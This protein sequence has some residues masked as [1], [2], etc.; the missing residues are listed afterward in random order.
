[1][2][3]RSLG[4]SGRFSIA[5]TLLLASVFFAAPSRA[6]QQQQHLIGELTTVDRAAGR[7]VVKSD[8]GASFSVATGERTVFR[9]VPPGQTS[10]Q[11]AERIDLSDLRVGDRVLVPGGA[12]AEGEAARQVVVMARE[13]IKSRRE[14]ERADWR[15]RGVGGRVVAIDAEKRE[16]TVEAR[17]REGAQTVT[18]VAGGDVRFRRFAQGSL[19]LEDA[20]QGT[21]ADVRVGDQL[22][23]LGERSGDGSRFTAEE[24]ISG[25]VARMTGVVETIDAARNELVVKDNQTGQT[26]TIVLVANTSIR[27]IPDDFMETLQ[28]RREERRG[29][30]GEANRQPGA[31]RGE[32]RGEGGEPDARRGERRGGGRGLQQLFENLPAITLSDLKKGDAVIVTGTTGADASRLTAASIVAGDA[33]FLRRMQRFQR[34]P[35]ARGNMSPGL[36]G[37]VM[38]G[39]TGSDQP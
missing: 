26:I 16:I 28:Q 9:R 7:L 33:E 13:A 20:V 39:N 25:S 18:V 4:A 36:P 12:P 5:S 24:I 32:R 17:S 2:V 35:G 30:G 8:A 29:A 19:R 21:F 14:G 27:R 6:Q 38:G 34:G 10:L 15:R 31:R 22:R 23:A 37:N 11:G 3:F 1:M